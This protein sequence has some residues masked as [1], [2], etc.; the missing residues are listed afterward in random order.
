M[1]ETGRLTDKT[2]KKALTTSENIKD[3]RAFWK[4][5]RHNLAEELS[6]ILA[7]EGR[8]ENRNVREQ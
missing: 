3:G 2:N 7:T 4:G 6:K 1:R 5:C 8:E